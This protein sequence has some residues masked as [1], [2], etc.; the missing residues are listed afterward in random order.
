MFKAETQQA[1]ELFSKI[2]L[3][4][5]ILNTQKAMSII[6]LDRILSFTA[7]FIMKD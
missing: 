5:S 4:C 1:A 3:L 7:Y 6:Y 2:P